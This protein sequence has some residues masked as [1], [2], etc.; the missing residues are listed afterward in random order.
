VPRFLSPAWIDALRAAVAAVPRA[1]AVDARDRPTPFTVRQEVTGT[2]DGVVR[3]DIHWS[4]DGIE[5]RTDPGGGADGGEPPDLVL[6]TDFPTAASLAR[7]EVTA[8]EALEAGRLTVRGR[9]ERVAS[10]RRVL[11]ALED[12]TSELRAATTYDAEP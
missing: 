9:L 1:D 3:Y 11:A 7:G 10:A 2:P 4:G 6:S 8:Q 12:R 5:V